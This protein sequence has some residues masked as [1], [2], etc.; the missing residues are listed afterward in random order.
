[1]TKMPSRSEG[2]LSEVWRR[3]KKNRAAMVGLAVLSVII[4]TAVFADFIVPY[5][6]TIAQNTSLRLQ[7]PGPGHWFGTD[8]Y[9]RDMFARVVHGSRVSL[10]I[11]ISVTFFAVAVGGMLG[12]A[13]GFYGGRV[14]NII[15]RV[16]DTLMCIPPVLLALAVVA[17]LGPNIRNLIIAM[18][19]SS[20]PSFVRIIRSVILTVVDHDYIEAARSYCAR[21]SRIIAKYIIPNAMGPIIV[22]ATMSIANMIISAAGL[23][24]IGMGVQPPA[25]E[26]GAMLSES[27]EYIRTAA[28]LLYFPGTAI[29]LSALSF[30]LIGD[31]LRDAL[32]PKLRD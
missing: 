9:G 1:M 22:Q 12:A 4:L 18:T 7:A 27:R 16:M 6:K 11:G 20:V 8:T 10:L 21:D 13:A 2:K 30:N 28:Y 19:I 24:F 32:D 25:P 5:S 15:M 29:L 17:A 3:M 26:W 31:G 14:D 23:S